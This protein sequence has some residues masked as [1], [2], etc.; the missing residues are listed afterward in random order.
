MEEM[1]IAAFQ[2]ISVIGQA[3]N[4]YISAV[5]YAR[6]G[7]VKKGREYIK[8]GDMMI[9]GAHKQHFGFI[10]KE[11]AGEILP[12]SILFMHAEDQ[13]L[14]TSTMKELCEQLLNVYEDL[15][16]LKDQNERK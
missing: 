8:E 9:Q 4:Y 2:M 3:K 16:N 12:F 7:D 5:E 11:A 15:Q 13:L 10:Q 6:K 14:S 1:Q